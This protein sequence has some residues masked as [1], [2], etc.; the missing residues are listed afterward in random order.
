MPE[1][2][3]RICTKYALLFDDIKLPTTVTF[4]SR[5]DGIDLPD[6]RYLKM[7]AAC[8]RVAHLSGAA[9]YFDK[10]VDDLDEGRSK[11]LS[12]DGSGSGILNVAMLANAGVQIQ[13]Y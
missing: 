9:E 5:V 3:Y 2:T 10:F 11:V 1:N 8:C 12:E 13:A 4:K 7:H 6:P